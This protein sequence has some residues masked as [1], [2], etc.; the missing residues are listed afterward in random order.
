MFTF[1]LFR[2]NQ[3]IL[4]FIWMCVWKLFYC[5][6]FSPF[7]ATCRKEMGD[8]SWKQQ[9]ARNLCQL[10]IQSEVILPHQIPDCSNMVCKSGHNFCG[11]IEWIAA[12]IHLSIHLM[13][14]MEEEDLWC[15]LFK[16]CRTVFTAGVSEGYHAEGPP[17]VLRGN[18]TG[19]AHACTIISVCGTVG[20]TGGR[21]PVALCQCERKSCCFLS[22]T[23]WQ[24]LKKKCNKGKWFLSLMWETGQ[25][26]GECDPFRVV[27]KAKRDGV[28]VKT[29]S[30]FRQVE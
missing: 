12:F 17:E 13:W 23:Q 30:L 25:K 16:W 19:R 7:C 4:C 15:H 10:N 20:S 14:K 1:T 21:W 2:P 22:I 3:C 26:A 6:L 18:L 11:I 28:T 5:L 27:L 29:L 9:D 24:V 8:F